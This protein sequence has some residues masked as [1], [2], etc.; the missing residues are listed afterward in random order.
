M[1]ANRTEHIRTVLKDGKP[2]FGSWM[3]IAN[4]SVAEIM[5]ASGFDWI[6]LDLEHGRM[7]EEQLPSLFRAIEAGGALP[8]ARIGQVS[9]YAIKVVMDS[10]AAGVILPMIESA[11]VL[12][13]AVAWAH[14]PPRGTRG[15]GYS[16]ANLFG[17]H[18]ERVLEETDPIIVAQIEHIRAVENIDAIMS[19]AGLDA[20][21]VGPYD[22][23]AS[24]GLTGQFDH[25]VFVDVL[26]KIAMASRK[27]GIPS[28]LHIVQPEPARV[29]AAVEAGHQFIAF[30]VDAVFLW[31]GARLPAIRPK[32]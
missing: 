30:G 22:M 17:K 31:D 14:Y 11:D 5:G 9:A 26:S 28:G 20:I 13:E 16:R 29:E 10:G 23:S 25:P 21:M 7:S 8:F 19:V 3:Q 4:D 6:A 24:M 15:V 2:T 32:C 18:F 1:N 27:H 12:R